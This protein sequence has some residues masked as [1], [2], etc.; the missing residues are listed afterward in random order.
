MQVGQVGQV[1]NW[2][3][4]LVCVS[5][6]GPEMMQVPGGP[7]PFTSST[8][9]DCGIHCC[10]GFGLLRKRGVVMS[11]EKI[12]E[13]TRFYS[14]LSVGVL[15]LDRP[16]RLGDLIRVFGNHTDFRQKV[17]SM[18]VNY[19]SVTEGQPGQRV[20]IKVVRRVRP[21]DAI[22]LSEE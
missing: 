17:T 5:A 2:E 14:R 9:V 6:S 12:G 18:Q 1:G 3:G 7:S 15:N 8:T 10:A 19:A 20:A 16:L 21:G 4:L 13:V 22:Y 11:E